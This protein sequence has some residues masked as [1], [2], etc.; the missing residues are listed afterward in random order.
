MISLMI[1]FASSIALLLLLRISLQ[2]YI[3]QHYF[4]IKILNT[5]K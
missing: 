5:T 4:T 3:N 1:D 2:I